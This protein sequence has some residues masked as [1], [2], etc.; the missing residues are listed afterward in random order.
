MEN[1]CVVTYWS[2]ADHS[3]ITYAVTWQ[4]T[5]HGN[6]AILNDKGKIW[7]VFNRNGKCV[8]H[9]KKKNRPPQEFIAYISNIVSFHGPNKD[10]AKSVTS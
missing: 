3:Y 7:K 1:E 5:P 6:I 2:H 8:S 10:I 9:H 4:Y